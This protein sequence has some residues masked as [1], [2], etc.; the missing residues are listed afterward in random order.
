MR[1]PW[2][3]RRSRFRSGGSPLRSRASSR[4]LSL[5]ART[6]SSR[7]RGSHVDTS[8]RPDRRR[9]RSA[10]AHRR[11]T[12]PDV[13]KL[14]M[15]IERGS[16]AD[17]AATERPGAETLRVDNQALAQATML[18]QQ[19][20]CSW[21]SNPVSSARRSGHAAATFSSRASWTS[22]TSP[23]SSI[24]ISKRRGVE[25][26]SYTT[27]TVI[28]PTSH[29]FVFAYVASVSE[30]HDASAAGSNSCGA[31]PRSSPPRCLGSSVTSWCRPSITT[32]CRD[33]PGTE[34]ALATR[35]MPRASSEGRGAASVP[36]R[37]STAGKYA[38]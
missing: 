26:L 25:V 6:I 22:S 29:P 27:S 14:R 5:P 12:Y 38:A 21:N 17:A 19:C 11:N 32:S 1:R 15:G 34:W 36:L 28:S 35:L 10:R 23:V 30:M 13:W 7:S 8:S 4:D 2:C 33:V 16:V 18:A 37:N 24:E 3:L 9:R 31:G 20:S